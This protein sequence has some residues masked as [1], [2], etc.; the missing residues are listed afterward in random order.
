MTFW[1][2]GC[3]IN[4][5]LNL[6]LFYRAGQ[7]LS[8]FINPARAGGTPQREGKRNMSRE[9]LGCCGAYCKTCKVYAQDLCKGCKIGYG[10]G[11]RDLSMA[12]C[13][14]KVCCIRRGLDSCAD[15]EAYETCETLLAFYGHESYKYRKYK[16]ATLFIRTHGYDAFFRLADRWNGAY[17]SYDKPAGPK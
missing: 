7:Q 4:Y 11:E 9:M 13:A 1:F 16:Q 15:C 6:R 10:T 5:N 12:K 3:K 8:I 17:G 2:G 14:M